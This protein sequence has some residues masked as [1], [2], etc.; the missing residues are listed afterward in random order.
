MSLAEPALW[1]G[2][3]GGSFG[4]S[5]LHR[6]RSEGSLFREHRAPWPCSLSPAGTRRGCLTQNHIQTLPCSTVSFMHDIW[7]QLRFP[8]KFQ[9]C[10]QPRKPHQNL[11]P[12]Q[13]IL[14]GG[15][16]VGLRTFRDTSG[17]VSCFSPCFLWLGLFQPL[18][19]AKQPCPRVGADSGKML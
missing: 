5:Q 2:R 14:W 15:E 16:A 10:G 6:Q 13:E 9:Q 19:R 12:T 8:H 7:G 18:A 3:K 11:H 17:R 1:W 4:K